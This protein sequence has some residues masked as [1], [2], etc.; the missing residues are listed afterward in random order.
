METPKNI[1][2]YNFSK[3]K[4]LPQTDND[5]YVSV[6][7]FA[8]GELRRQTKSIAG[9]LDGEEGSEPDYFL[10]KGLR[11]KGNSGNYSD[12]KIHIDDL[13][14]FINRVKKHHE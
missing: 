8:T 14:E 3:N 5:G 9:L 10:G 2:E 6:G 7:A 11:Y 12:M 4:Y 13:E 1:L